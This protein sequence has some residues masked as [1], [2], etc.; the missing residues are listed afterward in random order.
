MYE[1]INEIKNRIY[2]N[3]G[4][5]PPVFRQPV[6]PQPTYQTHSVLIH[7]APIQIPIPPALP[8][9]FSF[10]D[11]VFAIDSRIVIDRL[12]SSVFHLVIY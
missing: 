2:E 10:I 12:T 3:I 6:V 7:S 8:A 9:H 4:S 5:P 1:N 11:P